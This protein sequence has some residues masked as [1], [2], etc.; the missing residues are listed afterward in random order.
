MSIVILTVAIGFLA[1]G[2]WSIVVPERFL[3][4]FGSR[5]EGR[6][7]RAEVRAVYGGFGIA[8]AVILA[9]TSFDP[10]YRTGVLLV[11]AVALAGMAL[12][13]IL[14][15]MVDRGLSPLMA[16]TAIGEGLAALVL[17]LAI[18]S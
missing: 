16:G 11:T 14:S 15:G 7:G 6:D 17:Y 10:T 4:T 13:R 8:M 2:I 1:M 5:V 9:Y 3:R 12:G 18:A